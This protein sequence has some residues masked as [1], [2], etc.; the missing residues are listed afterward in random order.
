MIEVSKCLSVVMRMVLKS[1]ALVFILTAPI[2]SLEA[3]LMKTRS[4]QHVTRTEKA[5]TKSPTCSKSRLVLCILMDNQF[6]IFS[7][8][9]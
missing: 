3:F 5:E 1:V 8:R 7:F 6:S 4:V 2:L 9:L